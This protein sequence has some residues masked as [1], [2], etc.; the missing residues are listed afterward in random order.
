MRVPALGTISFTLTLILTF[1][2]WEREKWLPRLGQ[3]MAS[4]F[5]GSKRKIFWG[6]SHRYPLPLG[7]GTAVEPFLE[8]RRR[9]SRSKPL[10]RQGMDAA[11]SLI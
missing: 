10:V 11:T 2:L 1:S 5:M 7:E 8:I 9:R 6:K 3:K 4:R